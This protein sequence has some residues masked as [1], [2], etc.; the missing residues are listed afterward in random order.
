LLW[1]YLAWITAL[2]GAEVTA[3]LPEWRSGRRSVSPHH[4]RGDQL[5]LALAVLV[6]LKAARSHGSGLRTSEMVRELHAD[7]V[8]MQVILETLKNANVVALND[9]GRWLLARDLGSLSLHALCQTLGI[10]LAVTEGGRVA[11]LGGLIETLEGQERA[12]LS[13]S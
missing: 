4:R 5:S 3:A 11:R 7:P 10:S 9:S 12:M 2:I 13:R 6:M 8:R 1:M